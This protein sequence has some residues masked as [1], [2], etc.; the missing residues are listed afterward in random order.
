[1]HSFIANG[2][3]V[4]N[5]AA[6]VRDEFTGSWVLEAGVLVLADGGFALI[7]EFDKMSDRDRSAIHEAL[8]QQSYHHDFEL[9][10]AD[11][12]KVKIGELVDSLIEANRDKVILGK[13]TEI[14]PVEDIELLA[15]D[16]E[17]KEVVKV[18]ADRVS[19]HKA[20]NKFIR[21]RFSNGREITVTPEH[22][23][24]VWEDGEIRE[25]PAEEVKPDDLVLA[26]RRYLSPEGN[27]LDETTAKLLG[28]LLSEGFS[29]A[30][31]GNGYYEIGFTNTDEKLV[32][33]FKGLLEKLGIKYGVQIRE[34]PSEKRLYTVRV[35]SKDFY[36]KLLSEFPEAF[37]ER[38]DERPARRKRVPARVLGA[39][40][41]ARRAFLNAFFKGDGF[42]D[43]YRV[44]LTT[45]SRAMAEDLQDLLLSLGIYS[46]IFEENRG[47]TTYYKV[48]VSGTTDM[49]RF[50]EIVRDDPRIG[51][52][53]KLIEVSR[54]KR[55]YRDIV[56]TEVL[57]SL[58]DVLNVLHMNDGGLTNNI[59]ARQN[60]NRERVMD[61]LAKAEG[62]IAELKSALERGDVEA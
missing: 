61:Y 29:Y 31:P 13:D 12:R 46:Y 8:E 57:E 45:S 44:G 25:K 38:G 21:L 47:G 28:F 59:T 56:P 41:T 33:E 19:R 9:L 40:E 49:E 26:V 48:I 2:F 42:V 17:K 34:R 62:R 35:I 39:D 23:I 36:T 58:R 10:L 37:P 27:H 7:D 6:A 20:P 54:R 32:E 1:S 11:G 16:L 60:A 4:H 5:T 18:K 3:V 43:K 52:I 55:N 14:L 15:Y 50:A 22:P 30:N 51:K 53:E 24:M